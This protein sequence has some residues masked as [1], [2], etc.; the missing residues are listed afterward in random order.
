MAALPPL[1]PFGSS[2]TLGIF[3]GCVN[4][5]YQDP[6]YPRFAYNNTCGIQTISES[7]Y[8]AAVFK[9]NN[10]GGQL[11]QL[12]CYRKS[13]ANPSG[14]GKVDGMDDLFPCAINQRGE[15]VVELYMS[16]GQ[17]NLELICIDQLENN[18][19]KYGW[20]D[21]THPTAD[22]FPKQDLEGYLNQNL[23]QKALEHL[24]TIQ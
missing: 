23:V 5:L 22:P 2:N 8:A 14:H 12:R 6:A 21:I 17:V 11:D 1:G 9:L 18:R 13:R 3:N 16:S 15:A 4:D 10:P 24:L 19:C 7:V 20:L